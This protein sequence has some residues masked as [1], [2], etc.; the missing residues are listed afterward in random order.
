MRVPAASTGLERGDDLTVRLVKATTVIYAQQ[1]PTAVESAAPAAGAPALPLHPRHR[2]S[3]VRWSSL[4]SVS[5]SLG[6]PSYSPPSSSS[7]PPLSSSSSSS[8]GSLLHQQLAAQFSPAAPAGTG[9]P[10]T[11]PLPAPAPYGDEHIGRLLASKHASGSSASSD[12][13]S[14]VCSSAKQRPP[15]PSDQQGGVGLG[16]LLAQAHIAVTI[17]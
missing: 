2:R 13:S 17:H 3:N 11:V 9:W 12:H 14:S 6:P 16:A 1:Q 4:H 10:V 15:S 5:Q 8:L 7:T